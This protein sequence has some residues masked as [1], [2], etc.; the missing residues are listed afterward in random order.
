V[1]QDGVSEPKHSDLGGLYQRWDEK[2]E[3]K[4]YEGVAPRVNAA[5]APGQW[6]TLDITF[7]AP[8][9]DSSGRKTQNA[10]FVSVVVN[11]Q[12]AHENQQVTGPTRAAQYSDER[13]RGPILIQGDHGP[14]AIRKFVVTS[15]ELN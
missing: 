14:I 7:R 15:V 10:R 12:V 13:P 8:R 5:K 4:G 3:P 6:Q 9:F 2:R 11:G 1:G